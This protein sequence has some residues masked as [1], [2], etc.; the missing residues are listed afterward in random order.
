M[1]S[2]KLLKDLF[3]YENFITKEEAQKTINLLDETNKR[4]KDYWK[5]ISFYESYSSDYPEDNDPILEEFGLPKDWFSYLYKK[6][7]MAVAEVSNLPEPQ[8]SKISFH[9]QK[10]APGAFAPMHSDNSSND[11]VQGAFTRSKYAAFLYLNDNFEGGDLIFPQHGITVK[12]KTGMLAAF[13]GGHSNMHEVSLVKKNTRYTIGSF[14]DDREESDYP[15]EIRDAWA[16]ELAE[17]RAMQ[18]EQAVEWNDIREKGL[19]L[20]PTGYQY[21]AKEVE[22]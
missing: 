5:S 21:P 13:D 19:R 12:P 20:D 18:K 3:I 14:F 17:V 2:I 9:I 8:L 15:Q 10:W 4:R 6:F 16:K 11:G 1:S 22:L 7:R